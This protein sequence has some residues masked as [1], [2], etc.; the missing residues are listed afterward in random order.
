MGNDHCHVHV[1][2]INLRTSDR[3]EQGSGLTLAFARTAVNPG[4]DP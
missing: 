4:L 1:L 2:S 3:G